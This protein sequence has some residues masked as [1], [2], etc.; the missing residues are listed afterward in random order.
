VRIE[1]IIMDS[2]AVESATGMDLGANSK[3]DRDPRLKDALCEHGRVQAR[4]YLALRGQVGRLCGELGS[5]LAGACGSAA[6]VEPER[7]DAARCRANMSG[8]RVVIDGA[9]LYSLHSGDP[10]A[11]QALVRWRTVDAE[12]DGRPVRIEGQTELADDMNTGDD[13]RLKEVRIATVAPRTAPPPEP[14]PAR[15]PARAGRQGTRPRGERPQ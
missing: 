13:W 1:R 6:G 11:P 15:A 3:L 14:P 8:G 9:T 4:R 12:L 7:A 10:E 5:T 2:D